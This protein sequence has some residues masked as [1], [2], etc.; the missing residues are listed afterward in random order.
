[1][2]SYPLV[3]LCDCVSWLT[4]VPTER[5]VDFVRGQ[6]SALI[7]IAMDFKN[8]PDVERAA[9]HLKVN[10]A[11]VHAKKECHNRTEALLGVPASLLLDRQGRIDR[12]HPGAINKKAFTEKLLKQ[13]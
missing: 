10:Y 7:N 4:V 12:K 6:E 2:A 11:V 5:A 3:P 9:H 1:M 13:P 8:R